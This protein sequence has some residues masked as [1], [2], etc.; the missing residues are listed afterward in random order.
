[1]AKKIGFCCPV[2]DVNGKL[3][4][5]SAYLALSP[6]QLVANEVPWGENLR[7]EKGTGV[8]SFE[9]P[10]VRLSALWTGPAAGEPLPSPWP[11][12]GGPAELSG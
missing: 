9:L 4:H 11:R 7:E 3:P 8:F 12:L 10:Y 6:Q 2:L 1:M 5:G